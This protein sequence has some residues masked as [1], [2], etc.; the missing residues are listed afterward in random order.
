MKKK[1]LYFLV[2]AFLSNICIDHGIYAQTN[3][4]RLKNIE[5]ALPAIDEVFTNYAKENHFPGLVYGLIVD[6]KL[7]HTG[8]IG[9]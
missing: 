8:G 1:Y 2:I 6:G 4:I 3:A 5:A 7:V 9:Y